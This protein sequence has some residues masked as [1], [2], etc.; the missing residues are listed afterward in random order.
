MKAS[1]NDIKNVFVS[2]NGIKS[3]LKKFFIIEAAF[4]VVLTLLAIIFKEDS[5][6]VINFFGGLFIIISVVVALAIMFDNNNENDTYVTLLKQKNN[7][8]EYLLKQYNY[9]LKD[10]LI[11]KKIEKTLYTLE[12]NIS[13]VLPNLTRKCIL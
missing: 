8:E 5:G 6:F 11:T 13:K 1:K 7:L 4:A 10:N 3:K 2:E 12:Y 9:E